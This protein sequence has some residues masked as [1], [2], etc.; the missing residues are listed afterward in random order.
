MEVN[1]KLFRDKYVRNYVS[2]N[3]F[4]NTNFNRP[5]DGYLYAARLRFDLRDHCLLYTISPATA[6]TSTFT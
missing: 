6:V 2:S 1:I 4:L 3:I 5:N